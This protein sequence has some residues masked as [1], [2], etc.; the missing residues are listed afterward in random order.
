MRVPPLFIAA[1][2][3]ILAV[4]VGRTASA[5]FAPAGSPS[6]GAD[7]FGPGA[8]PPEAFAPGQFGPPPPPAEALPPANYQPNMLAWPRISP[9]DN[10]F[11]EHYV[12]DGLW[13]HERSN[14]PRQYYASAAAWVG[15]YRKPGR[16]MVGNPE[17]NAALP[18]PPRRDI[19]F[20]PAT[21]GAFFGDY[22][23]A[24]LVFQNGRLA[25]STERILQQVGE[26]EPTEVGV[27]AKW[28]F[29]EPD[30][31]GFELEG[32]WMP[33]T[34]FFFQR[35]SRAGGTAFFITVGLP[36][37]VGN[38]SAIGPVATNVQFNRFFRMDYE[39]QSAGGNMNWRFT[40]L[41]DTKILNAQPTVGMRYMFLREEFGFEGIRNPTLF[42]LLGN[43]GMPRLALPPG[44]IFADDVTSLLESRVETHLAGPQIG[45]HYQLGKGERFRISGQTDFGLLVNY[46][47]AQLRGF[48]IGDPNLPEFNPN[49]FFHK[50]TEHTRVSPMLASSIN[51]DLAIFPYIP[52]LRHWHLLDHARLTFGY[53]IIAVWEITRPHQ[54]IGYFG[55]PFT[56]ILIQDEQHAFYVQG[57]TVG[58]RWDW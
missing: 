46:E 50:E 28:G 31:T 58:L 56:P 44:L 49:L 16:E 6:G 35:G 38:T 4:S 21:T 34:D 3:M 52:V 10:R 39:Q 12:D 57:G 42:D 23:G 1:L 30:N 32:F 47:Q 45:M 26:G 5:Q 13:H 40:N 27:R 29:V 15:G 2:S 33:E 9:F 53:S 11:S 37:F 43:R 7:A 55:Q 19:R 22:I 41:I 36:L 25:L 20:Q 17:A 18:P 14:A 51:A 8:A 54:N 48:G 24:P